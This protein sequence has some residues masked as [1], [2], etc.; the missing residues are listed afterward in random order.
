MVEVELKTNLQTVLRLLETD[1]S[2]RR[3]WL[4]NKIGGT[5]WVVNLNHGKIHLSMENDAKAVWVLLKLD[6]NT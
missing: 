1:I 5:D 4:H 6:Q 3:Y 2:P